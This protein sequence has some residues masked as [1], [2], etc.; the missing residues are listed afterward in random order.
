MENSS[1]RKEC[2]Y[3]KENGVGG[4]SMKKKWCFKANESIGAAAG[5]TIRGTLGM[6][7]ESRNSNDKRETIPLGH[8]DPSAFPCFRTPLS[9][10]DA[11]IESL[12][13]SKFNSYSPSVGILPA[14]RAVAEYLS[15]DLTY[16]LS[17]DDVF[18]TVGCIQSI[19]VILSVLARPGANILLPRP[20][21]PIY[22]SRATFSNIEIRHFDLLPER[23]WEVDLEQVK[24]LADENT[25]GMVMVNP[26]NPC[27]NVLSYNHLKKIAETAKKL[28]ILIISDEVY[29]HLTFGSNKFFPM[30]LFGYIAPV[31]TLGSISKRWLVPGWRLGWVTVNDPNGYLNEA[32]IVDGLIGY[33]NISTDPTTFIQAAVPK[34]LE[35]T[36]EDFFD[37]I[38]SILRE[39]AEI[40]YD[41]IDKI[42]CIYCPHKPDGSMFVMVKIDTSLLENI[43]DDIDF[44]TKLAKEENVIIL[45]GICVGMKNW[46]RI[47]FAIEPARLED[48][49]RRMKAFCQR[50]AMIQ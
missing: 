17:P 43:K 19:E 32:K 8:G 23:G 37:N 26:G 40:C 4:V 9:A 25:V 30:G 39:S 48:G 21:F 15:R 24:A 31:I 42:D 28:G 13:S 46:L 16:K 2:A 22:E 29:G 7:M 20:G 34:I 35:E 47:T 45:P 41:E 27:G 44:C 14:R 36:K 33:M 18:L 10:E 49:L 3:E 12:R 1:A 50:H 6:L 38:I 11:I 5:I